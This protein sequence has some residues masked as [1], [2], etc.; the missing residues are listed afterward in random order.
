MEYRRITVDMSNIWKI[1]TRVFK[2]IRTNSSI[3]RN[4]PPMMSWKFNWK[5]YLK[6]KET[7]G[8]VQD[9]WWSAGFSNNPI[10]HLILFHIGNWQL[11]GQKKLARNGVNLKV[12]VLS[13]LFLTQLFGY[14]NSST[15]HIWRL[16]HLQSLPM[17]TNQWSAPWNRS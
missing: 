2:P 6:R 15:S 4:Y 17:Q 13:S 11:F 1:F 10:Y 8:N 9:H 5:N 14:T 12:Y 16:L 3:R 7:N